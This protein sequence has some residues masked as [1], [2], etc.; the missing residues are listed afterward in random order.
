MGPMYETPAEIKYFRSLSG[1]A[2]G[3][4]TLPEI[5]E[6]G[7]LGLNVLTLSLLTN[8]A[9]GIS[10]QSLTHEEVLINAE[11]SKDKMIKLLSGIIKRIKQ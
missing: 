1:S 2:V 10:D 8:F 7:S 11:R 5:E 9:A 3:M 4:S 6:A